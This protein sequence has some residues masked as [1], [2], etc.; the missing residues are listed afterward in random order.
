M[1]VLPAGASVDGPLVGRDREVDRI[2]DL[3]RSIDRGARFVVIRGEAGIG[4]T[5]LWRS[6]LQR[7]RAA[8]HRTLVTRA[9]RGGAVRSG[10][11]TGRPVRRRRTA[12]HWTSTPTATSAGGTCSTRS[13]A[14]PRRRR[15][16]SPSTT[17]SGSTRYRQVRCGTRSA[18]S[19]ASRCSCWRPNAPTASIA[20]GRPDDPARPPRGDLPRAAVARGDASGRVVD[21]RH[22]AAAHVG[23]GARA[24]RRQPDV[25]DRVGALGRPVRRLAGQRRCRRRCRGAL[26]SRVGAVPDEHAR[27]CS[28]V[29][30][31]LGAA[32]VQTIARG[33]GSAGRSRASSRPRSPTICWSSATT[34]SCASPTRCSRPWCSPAST[35][36]SVR[37]C[38]P[39][40]L[41]SSTIPM[42]GPVTSRCR[43]T[44]PTPRSRPSCTMRRPAPRAGVRRRWP[45]TSPNT[46]CGSRRQPTSRTGS[47]GVRRRAAPRRLPATSRR[48]SPRLTELVAMLPPGPIRAEAIADPRGDRLRRRRPVPRAGGRRGRRRRV[49][50]RADPRA[51]RVAGRHPPGRAGEGRAARRAGA[52]DRHPARRP[53][54]WRCSPPARLASAGMLLGRP[55]PRPDG[56]RAAPRRDDIGP[57]PRAIA[58]GRPRTALPVVRTARRGED[59]CSRTSTPRRSG[60]DRVPASVPHPRSGRP[61]DRVRKPRRIA[62]ELVDEGIE[63]ATDAGNAQAGCL[64]RVSARH[65]Q[66]PPRRRRPGDRGRHVLR[67]RVTEQDGRTRLVMAGHVLGLARAG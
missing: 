53:R 64:A 32:T 8:G 29:A 2:D 50:A 18:A 34:S 40:W 51:A 44:S 20:T 1:T 52:G 13:A 33:V 57:A 56:S 27:A 15:W 10:H 21:R 26:S 25:R 67:S 48:R 42:P 49:A 31:A 30:A 60:P 11:R 39:G 54:R 12:G 45:P 46:A 19:S 28:R 9:D 41:T 62:V 5:S 4:K 36:S 3:V 55:R 61:G 66:C 58:A 23:A 59:R 17:C 14:T 47:A 6:A 7:H 37:P 24:V 38:T 63:S 16:S 65:R 43:A 22:P 35:R